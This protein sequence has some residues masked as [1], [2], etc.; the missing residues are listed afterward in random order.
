M[1]LHMIT[2]VHNSLGNLTDIILVNE[3]S[4]HNLCVLYASAVRETYAIH[5]RGDAEN[6]DILQR[7]SS[8]LAIWCNRT[9]TRWPAHFTN[10]R[11]RDPS[12]T[13]WPIQRAVQ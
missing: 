11:N 2:I 13:S 12:K 10:R 1:F 7:K 8:T 9:G 3:H 5:H 6:A 4:L